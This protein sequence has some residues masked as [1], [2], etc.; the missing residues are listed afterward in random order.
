MNPFNPFNLRFRLRTNLRT[1]VPCNL[2][3]RLLCLLPL[4]AVA[5]PAPAYHNLVLEGGGIK[6]MAYGGALQVL[7]ERGLLAPIRRVGG[8]SA[9]AIQAALLA[10]GYTPQE[11]IRLTQQTP[12][13]EFNDSGFPL[14]GGGGRLFKQFGWYKGDAFTNYLV[15]LVKAKTG[16]GDL[17]LRQLH[18]RA[19]KG[20]ARDL[21]VTATNL[22]GQRAEVLSY[23]THPQLRVA[24]AVRAS[25]SLPLY[26]RAVFLDADD[27]VVRKP[28]KNEKLTVLVDGGL[29]A[30]YPIDLFDW[31]RFLPDSAVPRPADRRV[32]NPQTLGLRL[33][34]PAQ[35]ALDSAG[36]RELAPADIH[37]F[38]SYA[39]ALYTLT[40]EGLNRAV[41]RSDDWRR[42]VSI[43]TPPL[44]ARVRQLADPDRDALLESGRRA[45]RAFLARGK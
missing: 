32:T 13:Q 8:T 7:D 26:F 15:G 3:F 17:T 37:D 35:Y 10:V 20:E 38:T 31:P 27:H 1:T 6:G 14:I 19:L 34:V 40:H 41:L 22:T 16:D 33:D 5:Q 4:S 23:E 39:A 18:E 24:D 21:F 9:G 28:R 44:G 2:W 29:L 30:N 36:R 25:M 11:I 12:F 45:M 42:T 43:P